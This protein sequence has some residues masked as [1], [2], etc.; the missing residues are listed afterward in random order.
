ML[1][2]VSQGVFLGS[3]GLT[4]KVQQPSAISQQLGSRSMDVPMAQ[5]HEQPWDLGVVCSTIAGKKTCF[6][7]GYRWLIKIYCKKR[8][9]VWV[10]WF[11]GLTRTHLFCFFLY[12]T[13]CCLPRVTVGVSPDLTG[14][15]LF[16]MKW[17]VKSSMNL[18]VDHPSQCWCMLMLSLMYI[19]YNIYICIIIIFLLCFYFYCCCYYY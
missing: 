5:N 7:G 9:T 10:H 13:G 1:S 2:V 17:L 6:F 16:P 4:S 14:L 15:S 12:L 8:W 18:F 3:C 11:R 19:V